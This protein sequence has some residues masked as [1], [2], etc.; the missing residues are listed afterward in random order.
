MLQF[1]Y[2]LVVENVR[3]QEIV[4]GVY[5]TLVEDLFGDRRAASLFSFKHTRPPGSDPTLS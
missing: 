3:V 5:V 2:R 4:E 1:G